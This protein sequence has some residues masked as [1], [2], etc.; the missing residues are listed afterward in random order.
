MTWG[1]AGVLLLLAV[2]LFFAL[3]RSRR[4]LSSPCS[5]CTGGCTGGCAACPHAKSPPRRKGK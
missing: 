2:A 4:E 1:D 5:G 3:R